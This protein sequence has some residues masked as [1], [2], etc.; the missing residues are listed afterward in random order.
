MSTNEIDTSWFR[1]IVF[2]DENIAH[3][4]KLHGNSQ[5]ESFERYSMCKIYIERRVWTYTSDFTIEFAT[6]EICRDE[7]VQWFAEH[8]MIMFRTSKNNSELK[9]GALVRYKHD[10]E[11]NLDVGQVRE[12][13]G[14]ICSVYWR[15]F[16]QTLWYPLDDLET[17]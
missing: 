2:D 12:I 8:W 7:V 4:V 1:R 17:L 15:K 10:K 6:C 9:S 3:V 11:K 16:R 13:E 5:T 14:R